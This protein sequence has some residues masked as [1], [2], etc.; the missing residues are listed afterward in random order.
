MRLNNENQNR[1]AFEWLC[2]Q[3]DRAAHYNTLTRSDRRSRIEY[4]IFHFLFALYSNSVT[5]ALFNN[6]KN[7]RGGHPTKNCSPAINMSRNWVTNRLNPYSDWVNVAFQVTSWENYMQKSSNRES[8]SYPQWWLTITQH[9]T[10]VSFSTHV[11]RL[12]NKNINKKY[13]SYRNCL[14]KCYGTILI[15]SRLNQNGPVL[16]N[17]KRWLYTSSYVISLPY[18]EVCPFSSD[19]SVVAQYCRTELGYA[20]KSCW[21]ENRWRYE[22][23]IEIDYWT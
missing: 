7:E 4:A 8:L 16:S 12:A 19:C 3:T 21:E 9:K 6:Q 15:A 11:D 2:P 13:F 18:T 17:S 20:T 23:L 10:W 14:Q 1:W 5:W 22:Q